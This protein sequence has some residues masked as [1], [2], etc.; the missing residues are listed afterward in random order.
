MEAVALASLVGLGYGIS[1]LAGK[2][3]VV[4]TTEPF[5]T[6]NANM[7]MK[8]G[9]QTVALKAPPTSIYAT[10]PQGQSY[11][12][13][14]SELDLYYATPSGQT[15]PSE[16]SPG[17]YGTGL[18]YGSM[19]GQEQ[20]AEGFAPQPMSIEDATSQVRFFGNPNDG[21]TNYLEEGVIRTLSG[22]NINTKDFRHSNMVPFFGGSVKQNV[23]AN[24]NV[25]RLDAFTGADS[26]QVKKKEVEN[27]FDVN[28]PYGN[29]Y[30][31]E[32]STDFIESR[33]TAPMRRNNERPFEPTRVGPALGEKFGLT[34]KGGFQ[35]LEVNEIMK[36]AMP[37][38]DKLRVATNPKFSYDNP[39]IPGQ[40]FITS[41]AD[42]PGEVR[43][44]RPD[45][46]F[47]DETNSRVF[48]GPAA[49]VKEASRPIQLMP[50][51]TRTETSQEVI[52]TAGSTET[53]VPYVTGSYR[54]PMTQQYGGA[55]FRNADMNGYYTNDVDAKESDY[56]R[57]SFENRP[58]ERTATSTRTMALNLVPA[59]N[60]QVSIHYEDDARP[61][62]REE[63]ENQTREFG[64]A[65]GYAGG[66]P[67][68]TVWDPNDVARTTVK[69]T[70][71]E[72]NANYM[73]IINA[74]SQPNKLKVYDPNDIA[75]PTKKAELSNS[76]SWYGTGG[77]ARKSV[78]IEEAAYNMRTNPDKEKIAKGRRPIAGNGN[79]AVSNG[80]I[81]QTAKR[82][83][84]DDV[85]DRVNAVNRVTALPTGVADIGLVKYRA[86]LR[87]DMSS[88]RFAPEYVNAVV[89]NPLN[90]DLQRN[91]SKSFAD[92]EVY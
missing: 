58:N 21:D 6:S 42:S 1:K 2:K 12:G 41:A 5:V 78:L 85:N 76:L 26:T 79:I 52:G 88:E 87:L 53:F 3:E 51:T 47:V 84:T 15:I 31:L 86:P 33:V 40:H 17:P 4:K 14:P 36:Q 38:T 65:T 43:H 25:S 82:L 66:A 34:G 81:R 61:T 72:R 10:T 69:E 37:T 54:S 27:M 80:Y 19:R 46:F 56:G 18:Q 64:T 60:G 83:T 23:R 9:S 8:P 62:R 7:T 92:V 30:G 91:A 59:E 57:S 74:A 44:Y 71:V 77:D 55:G 49:V 39:V 75:K 89:N 90:Q 32:S 28:R 50:E 22:D 13:N 35:Q 70:M 11:R 48:T 73:G 24:A 45:R 29:P 67:M 63:L 16:P 68:V 20:T